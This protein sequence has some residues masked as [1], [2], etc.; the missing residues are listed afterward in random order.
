VVRQATGTASQGV[1]LAHERKAGMEYQDIILEKRDSIARITLNRP[2]ALNAFR[3]PMRV[4]IGAAIRD[5]RDDHWDADRGSQR[6]R[7]RFC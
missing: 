2:E 7:T 3:E 6:G 5:V 4:E 1:D